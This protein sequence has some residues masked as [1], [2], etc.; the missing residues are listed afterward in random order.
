L[1]DCKEHLRGRKLVEAL[2]AA[3]ETALAALLLA[4]KAR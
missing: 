2:G 4:G 1:I 3:V